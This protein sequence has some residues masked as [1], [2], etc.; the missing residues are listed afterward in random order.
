MNFRIMPELQWQYGYPMA[1]V[2][3]FLAGLAPYVYFK[4]KGWL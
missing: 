4:R 1:I 2:L 3:M